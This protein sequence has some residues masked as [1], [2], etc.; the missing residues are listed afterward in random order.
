MWT[1]AFPEESRTAAIRP[2]G[3]ARACIPGSGRIP[4]APAAEA[5]PPNLVLSRKGARHRGS[6]CPCPHGLHCARHCGN[7]VMK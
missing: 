1:Q 6:C 3:T 7:G 5:A 4:R 2:H